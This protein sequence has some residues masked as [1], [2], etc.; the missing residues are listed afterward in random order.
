[1]ASDVFQFSEANRGLPHSFLLSAHRPSIL[2]LQINYADSSLN[3]DSGCYFDD[4]MFAWGYARFRLVIDSELDCLAFA[5][6]CH[7]QQGVP[8]S[9]VELMGRFKQQSCGDSFNQNVFLK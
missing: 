4:I 1:M 9:V 5:C 8:F 7:V 6:D 3:P 2:L